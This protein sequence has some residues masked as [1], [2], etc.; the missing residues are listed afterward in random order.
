MLEK[1]IT[2]FLERVAQKVKSLHEILISKSKN[3]IKSLLNFKMPKAV[4]VGYEHS[5]LSC[6]A[7]LVPLAKKKLNWGV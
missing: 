1:K 3:L 5:N 7:V 6:T 2:Q 4:A